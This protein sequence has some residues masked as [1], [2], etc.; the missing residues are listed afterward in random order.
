MGMPTGITQTATN[1]GNTTTRINGKIS[2]DGGETC[3]ARFRYRRKQ[4]DQLQIGTTSHDLFGLIIK[5]G[6]DAVIH[7]TRQGTSHATDK[8][9][10]AKEVYT[11]STDS[12]GVRSDVYVDDT[13]DCRSIGGGIIGSNI[14]LFFGRYN[15][16]AATWYD[17]GYIKSTDLTG[18]SWGSYTPVAVGGS[19]TIFVPYGHMAATSTA[20][21]Y[22]Q[23][24]YGIVDSTHQIRLFKTTDYGDNWADAGVTIYSGATALTET[25]IA[26]I[27]DSK[28]IAL[29]RSAGGT[30]PLY[31]SQSADDGASWG[32]N[33]GDYDDGNVAV[34]NLHNGGSSDK[35]PWIIYD[36]E[37]DEV[38]ALYAD[39]ADSY[40]KL[41]RVDKDTVFGAETSWPSVILLAHG[42]IGNA[43][44]GSIVK[45]SSGRFFYVYGVYVSASDVDT[46]GGYYEEWVPTE[47]QNTL[48]TDSTYYED[49]IDL[50]IGVEYEFQTQAQNVG[51]GEGE[52]SESDTFETLV[53]RLLTG[54]AANTILKDTNS[55]L[56]L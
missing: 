13:Y 40:I 8:G 38:L 29:I 3:E 45:V 18:T 21:T 9:K 27:G 14:Y 15:Y 35:I 51:S 32:T 1:I 4:L 56:V 12:W 54:A 6:D 26:Y 48:E 22:L 19:L 44:Y 55:L 24:Y 17:L 31:Q 43:G 23:V 49:L 30:Y 33:D 16:G 34:T 20:G 10:I 53:G 46:W 39:R 37:T 41:C 28:L 7:F 36:S 25:S 52:W 42:S 47:W 11:P 5:T 2:D 50:E